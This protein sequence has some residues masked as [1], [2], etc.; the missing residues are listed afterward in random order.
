MCAFNGFYT[1]YAHAREIGLDC[2]ADRVLEI[3]ETPLVAEKRVQKARRSAPA[4]SVSVRHFNSEF[5]V[6]IAGR[7]GTMNLH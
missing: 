5:A 1:Q 3:A 4:K 6:E 2:L 7:P